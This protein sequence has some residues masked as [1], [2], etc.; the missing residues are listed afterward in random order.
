MWSFGRRIQRSAL[1][2][3]TIPF[4]DRFGRSSSKTLRFRTGLLPMTKD[5]ARQVWNNTSSS[6]TISSYAL[7]SIPP[8]QS[9]SSFDRK[10][11]DIVREDNNT[12]TTKSQPSLYASSQNKKPNNLLFRTRVESASASASRFHLPVLPANLL[13]LLDKPDQIIFQHFRLVVSDIS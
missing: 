3:L 11:V 1:D 7:Y 5:P 13:C 2:F 9:H 6:R 12:I 4:V 8:S 10:S